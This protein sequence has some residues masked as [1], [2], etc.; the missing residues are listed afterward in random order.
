MRSMKIVLA[1]LCLAVV[2]VMVAGCGGM[3]SGKPTIGQQAKDSSKLR[4]DTYAKAQAQ[5]PTPNVTNFPRRQT[6]ADSTVRQSLPNHPWYVYILGQNGN[7]VNYFV[8]KSVPVND[9]DYLSS[10]QDVHYHDGS[11]GGTYI[12]DAPS[13]EGIYQS[14]SGCSTLTFF[15]LTS[16][17]E[18]QVTVASLS[19]Y[20]SDRPLKVDAKP[21]KVKTG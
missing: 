6:L 19:T 5:V 12:L 7:V 20:V 1:L 15:D 13:L 16:N 11:G 8:A 4:A 17:A 9:C 10:T 2:G 21:I 3:A 14:A 18:I